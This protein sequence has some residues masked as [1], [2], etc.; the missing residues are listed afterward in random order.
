[1]DGRPHGRG[2]MWSEM[3]GYRYEGNFKKGGIAGSG[4]LF[5]PPPDDTRVVRYWQ[6]GHHHPSLLG[7]AV[8]W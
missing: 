4:A 8:K 1:M 2:I 5:T 3:T 7:D 6:E